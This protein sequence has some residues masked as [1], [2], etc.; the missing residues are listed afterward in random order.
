MKPY[1]STLNAV[2]KKRQAQGV[3]YPQLKK[4]PFKKISKKLA[5]KM[6]EYRALVKRLQ[7]LNG[8]NRSELTGAPATIISGFRLDPHHIQGKIGALLTNPF[9]IILVTREE[10]GAIEEERSPHTKEFMLALVR[11]RRLAQGFKEK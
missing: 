6:P 3:K 2:S 10:H 11:E 7:G 5:D 4:T 9:N 8:G 1:N